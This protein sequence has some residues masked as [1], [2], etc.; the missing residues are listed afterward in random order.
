LAGADLRIA[1]HGATQ[2]QRSETVSLVFDR[3][4]RASA[5]I[6]RYVVGGGDRDHAHQIEVALGR[7]LRGGK[8]GSLA[9]LGVAHDGKP[10]RHPCSEQVSRGAHDV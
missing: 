1:A 4:Q 2:Q 6:S 7:G 10:R 3:K 5:D 8:Q 9:S